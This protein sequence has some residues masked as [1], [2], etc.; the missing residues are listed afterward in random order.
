MASVKKPSLRERKY[1]QTKITL[2][3]AAVQRLNQTPFESLSVKDLCDNVLVSEA[4]FFNYFPRKSDLLAYI[5]QLWT[6][7]VSWQGQQVAR[8]T[9]GLPAIQAVFDR[10]AQQIQAQPRLMGELIAW[11]ARLREKPELASITLAERQLAFP[12][13]EGI[14]E[15]PGTGL[16]TL[17]A[18]NVQKAIDGG[19]LPGN[20]PINTV[21]VALLSIYYGVPLALRLANPA[22]IGNMYRQQ[23]LLLWAGLR[24]AVAGI[25]RTRSAG[26]AGL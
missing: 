18:A 1:A 22:A 6:L 25:E 2:M 7:E 4:T 19:D 10:T 17:L 24:G 12:E 20:T 3:K 16:E 11:Q 21:M 5:G 14:E 9:P 23:L 15:T 8:E 26:D 13:L